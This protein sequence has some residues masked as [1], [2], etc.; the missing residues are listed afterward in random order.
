MTM[1]TKLIVAASIGSLAAGSLSPAFA[2]DDADGPREGRFAA[3]MIDRY[4]ADKDGTV[5]LDEYLAVEDDRFEKADGDGDGFVTALEFESAM[6]GAAERRGGRMLDRLD[7]DKD[8]R[9][10]VAEA[11]A[12]AVERVKRR[13]ARLDK[14]QDGFIGKAELAGDKDRTASRRGSRMM[15]R[16]DTDKDG[17]ISTAEAGN[18][19]KMRFE[20]MDAD[21]DGTVT[22]AELTERM[23]KWRSGKRRHHGENR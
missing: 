14:D 4:D 23:A 10:S 3:R 20:Q 2:A 15:E 22:V 21:K 13:F 8:G 12:D 18:A 16:I 19:R 1:K 9:I 6:G 5:T 11:E 7:T 17:R